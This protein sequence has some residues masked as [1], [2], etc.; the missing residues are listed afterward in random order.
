VI[1]KFLAGCEKK[2]L[3]LDGVVPSVVG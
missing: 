3:C 1:L 2:G